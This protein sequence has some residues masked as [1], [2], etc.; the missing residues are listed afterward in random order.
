[1]FSSFFNKWR[2]HVQEENASVLDASR[3]QVRLWQKMLAT[4]HGRLSQ[5][6]TELLAVYERSLNNFAAHI[7]ELD[8]TALQEEAQSLEAIRSVLGNA[9]RRL[10]VSTKDDQELQEEWQEWQALLEAANSSLDDLQM[11]RLEMV[12]SELTI[13]G[14]RPAGAPS[15]ASEEASGSELPSVPVPSMS[16]T[17]FVEEQLDDLND[18]H[19]I[20]SRELEAAEGH[21]QERL[22]EA[23]T[24]A[25]RDPV[26]AA[27]VVARVRAW[28]GERKQFQRK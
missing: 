7:N 25:D 22:E 23:L 13:R 27:A 2:G 12:R 24:L 11:Q 3:E 28:H 16:R 14:K 5:E 21:W 15:E 8:A 10:E 4:E 26:Y 18:W 1:M 19:A 9:I 17:I 20:Y 6:L